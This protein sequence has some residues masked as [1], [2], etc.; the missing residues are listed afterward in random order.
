MQRRRADA[1]RAV[2]S[3]VGVSDTA[4]SICDRWTAGGGSDIRSLLVTLGLASG[5]TDSTAV[6]A[7]AFGAFR[8]DTGTA[9]ALHWHIPKDDREEFISGLRSM[10]FTWAYRAWF[11]ASN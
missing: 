5:T 9:C 1:A 6:T 4:A 2:S 8:A 3:H 11:L 7:A 10:L